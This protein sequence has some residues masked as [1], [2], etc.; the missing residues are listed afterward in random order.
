MN[1]SDFTIKQVSIYLGCT[2][3][4]LYG[5]Q[6]KLKD[7]GYWIKS[8]TGK[9]Y[10]TQEG[11]NYL[12]E[13]RTETMQES[14]KDFK[15]LDCKDLQSAANPTAAGESSELLKFLQ[16][17]I[18]ELKEEKEYWKNQ[19]EAK[20]QELQKKND[21]IMEWNVKAFSLLGTAED[22]KRQEQ[23]SKKG[24]FRRFFS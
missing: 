11:L 8:D 5:M 1:D 2:T 20:D 12:Q 17:Q 13:K 24:F 15:E 18:K 16:E 6:E 23:E 14:S 3:Q 10:I 7:L 9:N 4:N 22:N 21:Y 19:A